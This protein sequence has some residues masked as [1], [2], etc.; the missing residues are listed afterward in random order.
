[1]ATIVD[2]ASTSS[3]S[4]LINDSQENLVGCW[5]I[6]GVE[7]ANNNPLSQVKGELKLC[8]CFGNFL[9]TFT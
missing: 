1:M 4:R 8:A 6:S 9:K 2:A 5:Y 7:G 3:Q